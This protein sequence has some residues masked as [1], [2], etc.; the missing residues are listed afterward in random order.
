M[1][2]GTVLFALL[3]TASAAGLSYFGSD[4]NA[5]TRGELSVPGK[6]PLEFCPDDHSK[7]ILTIER[8]DLSPNPP[9]A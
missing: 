4:S 2:T 7:D 5:G 9:L 6:S 3:S 1:R 8:V